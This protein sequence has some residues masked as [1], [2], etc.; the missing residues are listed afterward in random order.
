MTDNIS[1]KVPHEIYKY[2]L[3]MYKISHIWFKLLITDQQHIRIQIKTVHV[4]R[5]LSDILH[6]CLHLCM[7][8]LM[9]HM[10]LHTDGMNVQDT[11]IEQPLVAR[12]YKISSG[13]VDG[14]LSC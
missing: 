14:F 11:N 6:K 10:F 8:T 2:L 4:I 5:M 3:S 1:G 12:Y 9:R 13:C 7:H